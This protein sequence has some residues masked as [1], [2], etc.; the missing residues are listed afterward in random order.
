MSLSG[1]RRQSSNCSSKGPHSK[2]GHATESFHAAAAAAVF[3]E[4]R[5]RRRA[6]S[7]FPRL[8]LPSSLASLVSSFSLPSLPSLPS[9]LSPSGYTY[10]HARIHTRTRMPHAYAYT[11]MHPRT[12]ACRS[13]AAPHAMGRLPPLRRG[14]S[15]VSRR[16]VTSSTRR[17]PRTPPRR[18]VPRR[19][20]RPP[21]PPRRRRCRVPRRRS[22]R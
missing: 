4:V 21:R 6:A 8:S 11:A 13:A 14:C 20:A 12:H 2:V 1:S 17:A 9:L 5:G 16:G 15:P 18:L 3:K 7:L 19:A 22:I 10:K